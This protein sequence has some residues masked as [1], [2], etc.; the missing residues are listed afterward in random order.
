MKQ[1]T[2]TFQKRILSSIL[3][4]FAFLLTTTAQ[5]VTVRPETGNLIGALSYSGG[6]NIEVGL[7][8]GF[9]ALWRHKQLPLSFMT[10]DDNVLTDAKILK[11]HANNMI[12]DSDGKL[13]ICASG[14]GYFVLA[15][16]KGYR[17]TGYKMVLK[18]K[19]TSRQSSL[20]NS[21]RIGTGEWSFG[22]ETVDEETKN[23]QAVAGQSF[24]FNRSSEQNA[25]NE[26]YT[27][28]RV[29]DNMSNILYFHLTGGGN[30]SQSYTYVAA[31]QIQSF[32]VTFEV[33]AEFETKLAPTSAS[34]TGVSVVYAPFKTGRVDLG[35][36]TYQV[37]HQ[38]NQ[39]VLC[40]N[41]NNVDDLSANNVIYEANAITNGAVDA[42]KGEGNITQVRRS[43][44]NQ[45]Y[46]GMKPDTYY[47]ETPTSATAQGNNEVPVGYRIIG[48]KIKYGLKA[49]GDSSS[50]AKVFTP[51]KR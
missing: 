31:L 30:S 2:T 9:S 32:E 43:A 19:W 41:Y 27:I 40:Y 1:T 6:G 33:D 46:Y 23:W 17:F 48:V 10:A 3:L 16:P 34:S 36:M 12:V 8:Y 25:T 28:E 11:N 26:E 18:D 39:S 4:L 35:P 44:D 22:E 21:V 5:N 49:S 15:L 38:G 51:E 37:P 24:T 13:T 47:V 45:Y 29:S 7:T 42:A 20:W 14:N 50:S